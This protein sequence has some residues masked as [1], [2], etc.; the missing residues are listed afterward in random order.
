MNRARIR[1]EMVIWGLKKG[2]V[3][4]MCHRKIHPCDL[5]DI[6]P[7][8]LLPKNKMMKFGHEEM[9]FM[10]KEKTLPKRL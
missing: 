2:D 5:Q 4:M 3:Y 7:L 1:R 8:E 6:G 9:K 10:L